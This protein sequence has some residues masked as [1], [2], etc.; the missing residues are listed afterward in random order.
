MRGPK[1]DLYL[2]RLCLAETKA[3]PVGGNIA[4]KSKVFF[5]D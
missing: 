2:L 1:P 3:T 5:S 4:V